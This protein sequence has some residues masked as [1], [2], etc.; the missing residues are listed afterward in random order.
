MKKLTPCKECG[1]PIGPANQTG[2]CSSCLFGEQTVVSPE[3]IPSESE[4]S[5]NSPKYLK[6]YKIIETIARGGMGVVYLA[7]QTDLKRMVAIKMILKGDEA[8]SEELKRFQSEAKSVASLSHPNIIDVYEIG[9]ESGHHFFSM[10]YVDG[11]NLTDLCKEGPLDGKKAANLILKVAKAI[12]YAHENGIIHR[13]LKPQNILLSSGEQIPKVADFG[14]A[15]NLEQMSLLTNPGTVMGSP[16]FMSPEQATGDWTNLKPQSDIYSIGAV[17]YY[18]ITGRAPFKASSPA[19]TMRQVLYSDPASPDLLNPDLDKDLN[20]IC[21]KCLEKKPEHRY[22]SAQELAQDL[23]RYTEGKTIHAKPSSQTEKFAKWA[24]RNPLSS[25][26]AVGLVVVGVLGFGGILYQLNKT[27]K[28][29]DEV[30]DLRLKEQTARAPKMDARLFFSAS[31]QVTSARLISKNNR[32][33]STDLGHGVTLWDVSKNKKVFD[34]NGHDGVVA[35]SVISKDGSR[36]FTF[37]YDTFTQNPKLD[38]DG[39]KIYSSRSHRYGDQSVI[40]WDLDSGKQIG[41][42]TINKQITS[43]DLSPDES[44]LAIGD[45]DGNLYLYNTDDFK[46][47]SKTRVF[48]SCV[49][50]VRFNNSGD[51]ILASSEG[52]RYNKTLTKNGGGGSTSTAYEPNMAICYN[53]SDLSEAFSLKNISQSNSFL[54]NFLVHDNQNSH[55]KAI[56]SPDGK[57]IATGSRNLENCAIWRAEDGKLLHKLKGHSHSVLELNF[58]NNSQYLVTGAADQKAIIWEVESG[59]KFLELEGHSDVITDVTFSPNDNW[60]ATASSDGS[61]RIW[62]SLSGVGLAV[63]SEHRSR[64]NSVEFSEDGLKVI[65]SSMDG[66]IGI[67][68]AAPFAE[69]TKVL[70]TDSYKP[71]GF[72]FNSTGSHLIS[73]G[74]YGQVNAW[75]LNDFSSIKFDHSYEKIPFKFDRQRYLDDVLHASIN[76]EGT[77]ALV[78]F[79]SPHLTR[80]NQLLPFSKPNKTVFQYKPLRLYDLKNGEVELGLPDKIYALKSAALSPNGKFIVAGGSSRIETQTRFTGLIKNGS[81]SKSE[82]QP[83]PIKLYVWDAASG[84]VLHVIEKHED[85]IIGIWFSH[86]SKSFLTSSFKNSYIWSFD[87]LDNP[88]KLQNKPYIQGL[89]FL[90]DKDH[91]IAF[92]GSVAGLYSLSTGEEKFKFTLNGQIAG[93]RFVAASNV[94]NIVACLDGTNR[95]YLC[96]LDNGQTVSEINIAR[97][98]LKTAA[99]SPDGKYLAFAGEDRIIHICDPIS[100]KLIRN[101][102]GHAQQVNHLHFSPD[103]FWLASSSDDYTVRMWPVQAF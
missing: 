101:L 94:N 1:K 64:V 84:K 78:L 46:Q 90:D 26:L 18:L 97:G 61:V 69:I 12:H 91:F 39:E 80:I 11:G 6:N 72:S 9:E 25:G 98:N 38:P 47:K 22:Q 70:K 102:E 29:L 66:G 86:D 10:E 54:R 96:D 32:I 58:S 71:L 59:E 62:S 35:G 77:K 50:L 7:E 56:W 2:V 8:S 87:D 37:S 20:T 24:K 17:L 28:A 99:F 21:L 13:D 3:F 92:G 89:E 100:G 53:V 14:I 83:T 63:Q 81:S 52:I 40:V 85:D 74:R 68:D 4:Q 75:N 57:Y 31:N 44:T 42:V 19:E 67:F 88:V 16:S 33:L 27:K 55:C 49:S 48:G 23:L 79:D 15:K 41:K 103:G 51:K 76:S 5:I 60:V 34:L 43:M 45:W 93:P 65:T 95:V 73:R 82:K 36:A 30:S